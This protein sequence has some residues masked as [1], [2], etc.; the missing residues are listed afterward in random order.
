MWI[1]GPNHFLLWGRKRGEGGGGLE[2][3]SLFIFRS[4]DRWTQSWHFFLS[5]FT[6]ISNL[7]G[8]TDKKVLEWNVLSLSPFI[9]TNWATLPKWPPLIKTLPGILVVKK[10]F[11]FWNS[12]W[13]TFWIQKVPYYTLSSLIK[14]AVTFSMALIPSEAGTNS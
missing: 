10:Y 13:N 3:N 11:F 7:I 8:F 9:D 2:D 5:I 12:S 4:A 6:S 14:S 1:I